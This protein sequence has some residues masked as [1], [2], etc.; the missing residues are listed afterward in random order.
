MLSPIKE[1][2]EKKSL[3][4]WNK[5]DLGSFPLPSLAHPYTV[6]V[7]AKTGEGIDQLS[8]MIEEKIWQK[9]SHPK[10]ELMITN[11]RH[12]QA[13]EKSVEALTKVIEGLRGE[14]S[15][16]FITFEMRSVLTSFGTILGT[17]ITED[18]LNSIFSRFCIGK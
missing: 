9:D 3:L 11:L 7:S 2:C 17:D 5:I 15:P 6:N 10:G 18:I 16:E 14:L 1:I 4:I 8:N 12:K 13:L